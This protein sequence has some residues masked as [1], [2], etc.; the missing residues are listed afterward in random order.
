M[1]SL[2]QSREKYMQEETGLN[3]GIL[4]EVQS[5]DNTCVGI[6]ETLGEQFRET[7]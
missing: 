6:V 4:S 1:C 2:L 3:Q 7:V 5:M